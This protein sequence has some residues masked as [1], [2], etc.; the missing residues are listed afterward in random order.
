MDYS[1]LPMRK[2]VNVYQNYVNDAVRLAQILK[3]VDIEDYASIRRMHEITLV[4]L[5]SVLTEII[6]RLNLKGEKK[7]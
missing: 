3:D 7:S 1:S 4:E 5:N 6:E 2:L